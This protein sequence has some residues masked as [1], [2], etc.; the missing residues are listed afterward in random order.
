[1][2]PEISLQFSQYPTI[3][4]YPAPDGSILHSTNLFL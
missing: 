4:L 1:M 2:E 3:R